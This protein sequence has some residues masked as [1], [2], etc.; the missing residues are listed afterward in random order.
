MPA[1]LIA[2]WSSDFEEESHQHQVFKVV[3]RAGLPASLL[4]L[5]HLNSFPPTL[6]QEFQILTVFKAI[7]SVLSSD[8]FGISVIEGNEEDGM[9]VVMW[10]DGFH[11]PPSALIK[12][13]S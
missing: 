10:G 1:L 9:W 2:P 5:S 13:F 3:L 12:I 4:A 6:L 11:F 7:I 8:S